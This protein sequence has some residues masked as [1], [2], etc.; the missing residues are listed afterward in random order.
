[1]IAFTKGTLDYIGTDYVFVDCSGVGFKVYT[2]ISEQLLRVGIG[3]DI[4]LYTYLSVREDA[5]V[6]FGFMDMESLEMFELL[7]GVNGVGPKSAL[8]MLSSISVSDLV[9]AISL[10]DK[11]VLTKIPGIGAKTAA[12]IVLD[13][14]DKLKLTSS[15]GVE[16]G[17]VTLPAAQIGQGPA[18]EAVM[19]L[20][21]LGY[22]E[23]EAKRAVSR[24]KGDGLS[25]EDIIRRSLKELY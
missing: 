15:E 25:V 17:D 4:K 9:R 6:L 20:V 8:G 11:K 2:P 14:K 22:S 5:M 21:S 10:D 24:S 13:L 7:I 12:R 1:M 16:I 19:A 23:T 3:G 18:A